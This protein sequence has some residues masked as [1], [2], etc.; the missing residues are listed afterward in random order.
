[1]A[2]SSPEQEKALSDLWQHDTYF[3]RSKKRIKEKRKMLV[4]SLGIPCHCEEF[5][6]AHPFKVDLENHSGQPLHTWNL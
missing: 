4:S 6:P 2:L 1:M 3:N 5:V